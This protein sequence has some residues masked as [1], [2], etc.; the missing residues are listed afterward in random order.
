M[1]I[2]VGELVQSPL[3]VKRG[4][5]RRVTHV[6]GTKISTWRVLDRC[7]MASENL[8]KSTA[9]I[10]QFALHPLSPYRTRHFA[11]SITPS[12]QCKRTTK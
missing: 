1:M 7:R 4:F 2:Q 11:V 8:L 5:P 3:V 12:G 10:F 6:L 9:Q